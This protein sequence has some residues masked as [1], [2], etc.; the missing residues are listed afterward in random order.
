[1][2]PGRFYKA[3]PEKET[4]K[5]AREICI[6][7]G[8]QAGGKGDLVIVTN[9]MNRFNHN[10]NDWLTKESIRLAA[11]LWIG[12]SDTV[13]HNENY[14]DNSVSPR[15]KKSSCLLSKINNSPDN[16]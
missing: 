16:I 15:A 7:E 9:Y 10:I 3:H 5:K 1:M 2:Y 12:A 6:E 14:R 13:R 4:W 11:A 8:R